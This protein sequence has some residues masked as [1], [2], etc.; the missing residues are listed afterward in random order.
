MFGRQPVLNIVLLA[1]RKCESTS[2]PIKE[3]PGGGMIFAAEEIWG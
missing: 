1:C 3:K 2:W